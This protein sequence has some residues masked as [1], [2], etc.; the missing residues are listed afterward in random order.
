MEIIICQEALTFHGEA[1]L[2]SVSSYSKKKEAF[3]QP[4]NCAQNKAAPAFPLDDRK[5]TEES[6]GTAIPSV[7]QNS[8]L[9]GSEL[10]GCSRDMKRTNR[11]EKFLF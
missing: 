3:R 5:F 6:A 7:T 1:V 8:T 4:G 9:A 10:Q 2:E 11:R